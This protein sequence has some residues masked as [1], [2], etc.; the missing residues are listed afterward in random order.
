MNR[1]DCCGSSCLAGDL[2]DMRAA[3]P[4]PPSQRYRRYFSVTNRLISEPL[5][6]AATDGNGRALTVIDAEFGASVVPEIE[7]GQVPLEMLA[8]DVLIGA[9]QPAFEDRKEAFEGVGMHVIARP[10]EFGVV[11]AFMPRDRRMLVVLRLIGHEA[12]IL[13]NV[14]ADHRADYAM[15]EDKGADVTAALHEAQDDGV[16]PFA[17]GAA[18]GLARIGDGGFVGFHGLA[19]AAHGASCAGVH[20][21]ADA[22]AKVPSGFHA[23]TEHP[24]KL[25]GRHAF[26]A[27]AQQMDGLQPQPQRQMAIL[28][29]GADPHGERLPAGV[30]FAQARPGG[31]ASEAADALLI[32]VAAMRAN[33]TIRPKLAFDIFERGVLAVEAVIGKNGVGHGCNL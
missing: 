4:Q 33:R 10:L 29:N 13:V 9:D 7:L 19:S 18:T 30:A 23:A 20:G 22:V 24:L 26:L 25:A 28:E 32:N 3:I 16:R 8:V 27:G 15:V 11:H 2:R 12:A 6:L 21:E 14:A 1:L 5:A 17:A 31:L